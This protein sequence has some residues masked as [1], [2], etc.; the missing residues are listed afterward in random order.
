LNHGSCK[1]KLKTNFSTAKQVYLQKMV[2]DFSQGCDRHLTQHKKHIRKLYYILIKNISIKPGSFNNKI[3]PQIISQLKREL[4]CKNLYLLPLGPIK[5]HS[6]Q[7]ELLSASGFAKG[8]KSARNN[9][10]F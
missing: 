3:A 10:Q 5:A 1:A 8:V 9:A 6:L 7:M 2:S 4:L